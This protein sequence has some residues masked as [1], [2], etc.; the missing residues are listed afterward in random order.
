M[1]T[2]PN[3]VDKVLFQHLILL[4]CVMWF[5]EGWDALRHAAK[6]GH[7]DVVQTLINYGVDVSVMDKVTTI[8]LIEELLMICIYI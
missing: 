4:I 7:S 2:D 5:Q 1:G 3:I 6:N 8:L